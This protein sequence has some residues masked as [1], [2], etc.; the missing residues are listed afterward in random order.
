LKLQNNPRIAL[1]VTAGGLQIGFTEL[2][3]SYPKSY[4][5]LSQGYKI[6]QAWAEGYKQVLK[7]YCKVVPKVT[8]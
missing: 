1:K 7:K 4:F 6:P 2:P 8:A 3:Q 5:G